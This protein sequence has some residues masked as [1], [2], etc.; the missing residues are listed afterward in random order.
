MVYLRVDDVHSIFHFE[1][2]STESVWYS[3]VGHGALG[4]IILKLTP[5][6]QYGIRNLPKNL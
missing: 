1:V 3:A 4:L 5:Q 6:S 2:D